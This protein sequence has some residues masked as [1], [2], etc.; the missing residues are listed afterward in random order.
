M[1]ACDNF[2]TIRHR[3]EYSSKQVQTVSLQPNYIFT[4][5]GKTRNSTKTFNC[6]LQCVLLNRLFQ[7]SAESRKPFNV[8]FVPYLL[9]NSFSCLLTKNLLHTHV[10]YQK[11]IFILNMVH[12]SM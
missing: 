3:N 11:F 7:I 12:F 8:H 4:L 10:F 1:T 5:L 2:C 9:E 6:L